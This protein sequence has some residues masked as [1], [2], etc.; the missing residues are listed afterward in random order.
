MRWTARTSFALFL[1][2]L[3]AP[4]AERSVSVVRRVAFP[5]LAVSHTLHLGAILWLAQLTGGE[6]IT[7]R[8]NA[9]LLGS[10]VVAYSWIYF[11]AWKPEHP[12]ADLGLAWLWIVFAGAY[13]PRVRAEPAAFGVAGLLLLLSLLVRLP[14]FWRT[15]RPRSATP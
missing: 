7:S 8:A 2:A 14:G 5:L 3:V 10:G 6:N 13:L 1:L 4:L 12:F 15:I 9:V 11:L